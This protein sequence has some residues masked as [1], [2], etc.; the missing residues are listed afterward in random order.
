MDNANQPN[1]FDRV[2]RRP[3]G[4]SL[5]KGQGH[6]WFRAGESVVD[7][8]ASYIVLMRL[9]EMRDSL[10]EQS[11]IKEIRSNLVITHGEPNDPPDGWNPFSACVMV[12]EAGLL[13]TFSPVQHL[14]P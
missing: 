9:M 4:D 10:W 13:L 2:R 5:R 12:D 14:P 7:K 6:D 8:D 1:G 3:V 11:K